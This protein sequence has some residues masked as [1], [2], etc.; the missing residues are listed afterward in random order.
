MERWNQGQQGWVVR[1]WVLIDLSQ[2]S[3][4]LEALLVATANYQ[5]YNRLWV[6]M[7]I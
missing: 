6:Y 7:S 1:S 5:S 4:L 3:Q 2:P